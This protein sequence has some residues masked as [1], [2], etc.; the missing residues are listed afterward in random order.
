MLAH[1]QRQLG[2]QVNKT[3]ADFLF[4]FFGWVDILLA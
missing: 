1:G 3:L 4:F 2:P